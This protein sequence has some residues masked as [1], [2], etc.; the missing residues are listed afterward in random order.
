MPVTLGAVSTLASEVAP[1]LPWA[2]CC[3][4]EQSES[5]LPRNPEEGGLLHGFLTPPAAES[6]QIRVTTGFDYSYVNLAGHS[7]W[8][9]ISVYFVF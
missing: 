1:A 4:H 5:S 9:L 7:L 8:H 2:G 6:Q 3:S